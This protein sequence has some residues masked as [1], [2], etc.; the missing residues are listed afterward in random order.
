MICG[1]TAFL[2]TNLTKFQLA[3]IYATGPIFSFFACTVGLSLIYIINLN[4]A[5]Y[6][7]LVG[8]VC[9]NL[10]CLLRNLLPFHL[11]GPESND[12]PSDGLQ[13]VRIIRAKTTT[14]A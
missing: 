11:Q 4:I 12:V 5:L 6:A 3:L 10:L 13:I 1:Y 14:E 7:L 9:S 2:D 8:W